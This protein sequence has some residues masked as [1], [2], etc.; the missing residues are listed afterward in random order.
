MLKKILLLSL[1]I[2]PTVIYA[3]HHDMDS[4]PSHKGHI[5]NVR[6]Q[7]KTENGYL[8][9]TVKGKEFKTKYSVVGDRLRIQH[10]ASQ[11]PTDLYKVNKG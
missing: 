11:K 2:S 7:W 8:L 10:Q 5:H 6:G 4:M 3:G 1:L 9:E